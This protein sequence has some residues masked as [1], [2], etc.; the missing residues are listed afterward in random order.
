MENKDTFPSMNEPTDN[1]KWAASINKE[2][3]A[4]S[5]ALKPPAYPK[6]KFTAPDNT[7][8][9]DSIDSMPIDVLDG[10]LMRN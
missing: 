6:A 8:N 9:L 1:L 7:D 3:K 10:A 4:T 2:R 5:N